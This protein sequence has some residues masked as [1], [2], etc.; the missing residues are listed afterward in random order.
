VGKSSIMNKIFKRKDLVKVSQRPGRTQ[1]ANF[2]NVEDVDF[3]DLPGY[4]FA[5][6][7]ISE[8]KKWEL[9]IDG[10]FKQPR[11]H[12]LCVLLVDIRHDAS[13]LDKQMVEY[14]LDNEIPFVICFTKADKLS[15]PKQK[16]QMATL[17]KQFAFAGDV[18]VL[19]CSAVSG[20]GVDDLR[21]IIADAVA[22]E[23]AA[24]SEGQ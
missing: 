2:F 18:Y 19:S 12:A 13:P 6:V 15:R 17:C 14:L 24:F 4:G 7:P 22:Q 20:Q 16:K 3:V 9:L 1:A 5:K 21:A 23:R 11:R 8:K 10:Y